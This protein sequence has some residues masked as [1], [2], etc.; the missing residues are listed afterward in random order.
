MKTS[1]IAQNVT[2]EGVFQALKTLA[3]N[4]QFGYA[5][6]WAKDGKWIVGMFGETT[7]KWHGYTFLGSRLVWESTVN[8]VRGVKPGE[9]GGVD[10]ALKTLR[11]AARDIVRQAR[12]VPGVLGQPQRAF[13]LIEM[14]VVMLIGLLLVTLLLPAVRHA[15]D[16]AR[17]SR[18]MSQSRQIA[19]AVAAYQSSN[20]VF[21]FADGLI[22][23]VDHDP[24]TLA[25]PLEIGDVQNP[26]VWFCP[27][28]KS[29]EYDIYSTYIY[30][31]GVA[32]QLYLSRVRPVTNLYDEE[33][34][35]PVVFEAMDL[36]G[37]KRM[38]VIADGSATLAE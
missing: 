32:M 25:L 16:A 10:A 29:E 11:E 2:V 6:L 9:N 22:A 1:V 24:Y 30:G 18:C 3:D 20:G 33:P 12:R 35:R 19:L 38:K 27:A 14:L 34:D 17:T 15:R 4:G 28:H 5:C 21:P 37:G 23:P 26:G 31:P 36:H 13:T 8:A 7:P